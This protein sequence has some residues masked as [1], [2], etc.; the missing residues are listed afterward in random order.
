MRIQPAG[1]GLIN[2]ATTYRLDTHVWNQYFLGSNDKRKEDSV[3]QPVD[4]AYKSG[5]IGMNDA[6]NVKTRGLYVRMLSHGP[7]VEADYLV[8]DWMFGL[9]NT[10]AAADRKGWMS[11]T[12]DFTSSPPALDDSTWGAS[13]RKTIRTRVADSS[14]VLRNKVFGQA[15]V[16]WDGTYLID[17]EEVSLI[18]TSD[19]AKGKCVSYMMFGFIQNRAQALKLDSAVAAV[20]AGG[21]RRRTGR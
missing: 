16:T 17:D 7:G 13:L 21:N 2:G 8:G 12:I 10:V 11:Q 6:V 9:F 1:A 5:H 3:A 20:R 4:W 19:S 15:G 14:G 18:A